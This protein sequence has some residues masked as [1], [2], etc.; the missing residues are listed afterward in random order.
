M[1]VK[2]DSIPVDIQNDFRTSL[3]R[4]T[5]TDEGVFRY[6][7]IRRTAPDSWES[8]RIVVLVIDENGIAMPSVKVAFAYS[9]A[10][11]YLVGPD[12]KWTP[13][14]PF[15]ADIFSTEGN[16]QIEHVQ[17]SVVKPGEPGGITVFIA[18]PN[19]SSDVVSGCGM[20]PD[21]HTGQY[22]VLQCQRFGVVPLMDRLEDIE[23]RI[24]SIE[25]K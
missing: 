16:G 6:Y 25:N 24:T 17:G 13:P 12:W 4:E 21:G 5:P 1:L 7:S 10:N 19:I 14:G 22:I 11:Q 8:Q 15:R 3:K 23:A 2:L 20:L 18:E 9:T